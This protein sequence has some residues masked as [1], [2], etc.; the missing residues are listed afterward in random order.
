MG[1]DWQEDIS[2]GA[3]IVVS[4]ITELQAS[5]DTFSSN[6]CSAYNASV[7][8]SD[9]GTVEATNYS[10]VDSGDNGTYDAT[11]NASVDATDNGTIDTTKHNTVDTTDNGTAQASHDSSVNDGDNTR[12]NDFNM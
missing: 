8:V 3:T 5:I 12:Y 2:I 7:D 9:D 11:K 10:S 1:F 4:A 6:R